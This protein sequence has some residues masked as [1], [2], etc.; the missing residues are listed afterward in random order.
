MRSDFS[1]NNNNITEK[2]LPCQLTCVKIL[3]K[4]HQTR[5]FY[6]VPVQVAVIYFTYVR[7]LTV[8]ITSFFVIFI[9]VR[10][11]PR[12]T[13][14]FG[15]ARDAVKQHHLEGRQPADASAAIAAAAACAAASGAA[16]GQVAGDVCIISYVVRGCC[17][18]RCCFSHSAYCICCQ[19][20][21]NLLYMVANPARG[22]LNREKRTKRKIMA[23]PPPP[24]PK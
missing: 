6:D 8:V 5:V 7:A 23:A 15:R 3:H 4:I 20:G 13:Q 2:I 18:C 19:L 21:K 11:T 14:A 17:C 24:L 10:M 22:L 9:F 12:L 1:F 16:L